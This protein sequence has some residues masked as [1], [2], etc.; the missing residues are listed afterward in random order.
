M[1]TPRVILLMTR[2]E[3]AGR[4]FVAGLPGT[5]RE[6]ITPC[7]APLMEIVPT[8]GP[9]EIGAARGLIFSSAAGVEA[10]A[11][12]VKARDLPCF[13]VGET[14]AQAARDAGWSRA[15]AVALDAEGLLARLTCDPP[16]GP[17]L[18]LR[19]AHARVPIAAR[20]S[21]AGLPARE[22]VVYD[23]PERALTDEARD[24]LEGARPVLVPLFSPRSA[25]LFAQ[26]HAG[27]APLRLL[28]MSP[29]VADVVAGLDAASLEVAGEPTGAAMRSL[30]AKHVETLSPC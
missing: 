23:Q 28:A 2:P 15:R 18:H 12:R 5:M 4:R 13:C 10:V 7:Y 8:T 16:E 6:R 30:V 22:A 29:A 21:E 1:T 27:G 17:L 24:H 11:D 26:G 14:S 25:R 20:L 19:G 9:V 3:A